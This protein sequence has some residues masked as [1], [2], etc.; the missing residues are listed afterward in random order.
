MRV[1]V[2]LGGNALLERDERPDAVIQ[3]RQVRQAAEAL[4]SLAA[5]HQ[6]VLGPRQRA[7]GG[8][9]RPGESGGY[10]AQ[11]AVSARC[12]GRPAAIR[13]LTDATDV[14]AGRADTTSSAARPSVPQPA[15]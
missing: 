5:D 10:Q 13:A 3:R 11:P 15:R 9:A 4:V 1:V 8:G 14:L 2:A 12:P 6:L 7:A